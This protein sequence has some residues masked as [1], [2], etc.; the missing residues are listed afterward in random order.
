MTDTQQVWLSRPAY[1]RLKGELAELLR[2]RSGALGGN[3]SSEAGDDT[4]ELDNVQELVDQRDR[5]ARIRKLQEMLRDPLVGHEP[6]DDGVVEQGMMITVRYMDGV[7]TERFLLA[8]R[9]GADDLDVET[10]SPDSPLGEALL[11]AREGEQ[12][13][14]LLPDGSLTKVTLVQAVPYRP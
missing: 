1:E 6:P 11:G 4:T 9:A 2:R 5:E 12:R 8:D 10:C 14:L 7:G 3:A 13:E